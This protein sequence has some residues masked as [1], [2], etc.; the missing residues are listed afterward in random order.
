MYSSHG[1]D[2]NSYSVL[3]LAK[4]SITS[5]LISN[6]IILKVLKTPLSLLDTY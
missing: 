5:Q 4:D 1:G 6:F 3:K 2:K